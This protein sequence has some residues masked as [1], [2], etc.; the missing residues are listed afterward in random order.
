MKMGINRLDWFLVLPLC[1]SVVM[2][3]E[4][5]PPRESVLAIAQW[6]Q[7][8]ILV[9]LTLCVGVV[10]ALLSALDRR[11]TEDYLFQIMANAALVGVAVSMF[12]HL[13]WVIGIKMYDLPDLSAENMVGVT[14]FAWIFSYYWFRFKGIAQ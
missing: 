3:A 2:A 4:I 8:A 5:D 10:I 9:P 6:E 11:C 13:I 14:T 7:A 12:I 1:A